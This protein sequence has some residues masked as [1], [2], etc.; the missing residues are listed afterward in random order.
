MSYD[1]SIV[2]CPDY[3]PETARAALLEAI[4]PVGGLD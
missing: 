4:A 2:A 1:V 3:A